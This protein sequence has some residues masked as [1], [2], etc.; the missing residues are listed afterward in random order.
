M[1]DVNF[2][3]LG[4]FRLYFTGIAGQAFSSLRIKTPW[5]QV[6]TDIDGYRA[7]MLKV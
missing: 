6:K 2:I 1:I 5:M 3:A 7:Q 4:C